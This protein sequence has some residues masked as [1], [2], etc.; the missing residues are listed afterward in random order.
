MKLRNKENRIK[1]GLFERMTYASGSVGFSVCFMAISGYL[2][3]VFTDVFHLNPITAANIFLFT[4]IWDAIND[5]IMGAVV[6]TRPFAKRGRGAYRPWILLSIPCLVITF[7][8]CFTMPGFIKTEAGKTAWAVIVYILYTMSQTLGQVPFGSLSNA[9]TTDTQERGL[10]GSYRNFGE[11]LGGLIVSLL[12]MGLVGIFGGN[13][14]NPA[15]G[16]AGAAWV[17]GI[18]SAAALFMCYKF[19]HE[20]GIEDQKSDKNHSAGLRASLKMLVKNRPTLC[21]VAALF[22]AAIIINFRFAYNMYYVQNY[23]NGGAGMVTTIN[24]LQTAVSIGAFWVV[25]FMFRHFEKKSMLILCA[26]LFFADGI[27]FLIAGTSYAVVLAA[28][29][30]FGFCMTL[31]FSTIWGTIPD[32]VEYGL[33]KT[34]ICAPAFQFAIVTFAQKCGIGIASWLAGFSLDAV[35]Y[36]AGQAV[37]EATANGIYYWNFGVLLMGGIVFLAAVLP[38][39]LSRK[40]YCDI[41]RELDQGM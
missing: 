15:A 25:N 12:I 14:K 33:W 6:D 35:G 39:N 31:S 37:S 26:V 32:G 23:L 24:S 1:L 4:R 9:M 5:P 11:N 28:S 13:G 3:Y 38:Y 30:L 29:A 19:T 18:I 27:L 41:I 21:M 36:K 8:L 2:L 20:R 10:L 7:G 17:L 40:K 34:G 16:F 22:I